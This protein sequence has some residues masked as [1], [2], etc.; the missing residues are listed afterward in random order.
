MDL[1]HFLYNVW[2]KLI[3]SCEVNLFRS[4]TRGGLAL[5]APGTGIE[6]LRI[7]VPTNLSLHGA[8]KA[9]AMICSSS[10]TYQYLGQKTHLISPPGYGVEAKTAFQRI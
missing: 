8:R 7:E 6:S 10:L 1:Q 5:A 2:A 9:S 3:G 4:P